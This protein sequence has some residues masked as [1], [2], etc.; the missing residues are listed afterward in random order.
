MP[1]V[2]SVVDDL[3]ANPPARADHGDLHRPPS[4]ETGLT[5]PDRLRQMPGLDVEQATLRRPAGL[6]ETRR[7]AHPGARGIAAVFILPGAFEHEDLLPA[8]MAR[9][10]HRGPGAPSLQL[11]RFGRHGVKRQN[12]DTGRARCG[13]VRVARIHDHLLGIGARELVQLHEDR[14]AFGPD[15]RTVR[16]ADG[17]AHIGADRVVA[18]LVREHAVKHEVFLAPAMGMG[19]EGAV[20]GEAHDG[21]RARDLLADPVQHHAVDATGGRSD[22]VVIPGPDHDPLGEIGVQSHG[23]ALPFVVLW[24]WP[25]ARRLQAVYGA[26]S[27]RICCRNTSMGTVCPSRRKCQ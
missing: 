25:R 1:A 10:R 5:R 9:G 16:R 17:I 23:G 6:R 13:E 19:V 26:I 4:P 12:L 21:R 15:M 11:H 2:Q 22:P 14:R 18:C 24:R 20:R 27:A 7:V 8:L 3:P